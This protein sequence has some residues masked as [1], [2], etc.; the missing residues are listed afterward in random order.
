VFKPRFS[1]SPAMTRALMAI[2]ADRQAVLALPID[3]PMLASLRATAQLLATHYST[4]IEGNRLTAQ[5]VQ[6]VIGGSRFPGRERDEREVRHYYAAL[7]HVETLAK[8]PLPLRETDIQ[9]LTGLVMTG[10]AKPQ[11]YRDGQNVIR[12]AATNRIVY[13]PPEAKEVPDLMRAMVDWLNTEAERGEWPVPVVAGIAHYQF[14]TIHPYYDGNGRT[15]RL[16]TTLLLHRH[17]YGLK[18]IY[19]L[20]EYYARD[21]GG[22]YQALTIGPSHNYHLGRAEADLSPFLDYFLTGMADAFAHVR[23]QAAKAASRGATDQS[24]SLRQ[25]DPRQRTALDLFRTQG[26]ASA[27]ELARHLGLTP[28]S[29]RPICSRWVASGFLITADPS[30]RNRL[31]RLAPAFEAIATA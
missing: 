25:L 6:E 2:E 3:V 7:A 12:D 10:K 22:Y 8:K 11:P 9:T 27:A 20:E 18:G 30:R 16:L 15:A 4:Q 13:L 31:Y 14:A 17:G 19:A 23:V 26:S 5:Q 28:R 1:L 24:P 21:L 29:M